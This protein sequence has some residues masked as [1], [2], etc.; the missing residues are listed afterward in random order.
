MS[1]IGTVSDGLLQDRCTG[2][3][4]SFETAETFYLGSLQSRQVLYDVGLVSSLIRTP[5]TTASPQVLSDLVRQGDLSE[6][7]ACQIVED[8]LFHNAN[9]LYGLGWKPD[10]TKL[11]IPSA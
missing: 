6:P 3:I 7:Q 10:S 2:L 1:Q 9:V 5:L 8:M 11:S 4:R